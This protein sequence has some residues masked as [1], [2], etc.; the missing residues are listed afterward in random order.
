MLEVG[1]RL[2]IPSSIPSNESHGVFWKGDRG[3]VVFAPV[4]LGGVWG[5]RGLVFCFGRCLWGGLWVACGGFCL[6]GW[7]GGRAFFADPSGVNSLCVRGVGGVF[8]M[9]GGLLGVY[10]ES[11]AWWISGRRRMAQASRDQR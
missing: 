11:R 4:L 2:P 8:R 1:W 10:R 9:G 6:G 7:M 5:W 3:W